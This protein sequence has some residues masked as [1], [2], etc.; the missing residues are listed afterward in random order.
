MSIKFNKK[1]LKSAVLIG[2]PI[3]ACGVGVGVYV[4]VK[5]KTS[6]QTTVIAERNGS[7]SSTTHEEQVHQQNALTNI[8]NVEV[9]PRL[10][11]YDF[12]DQIR[13]VEGKQ[14]I[15]DEFIAAVVNKVIKEMVVTD[16]DIL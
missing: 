3:V 9:F 11:T 8:G 13:I 4:A 12:Y 6:N 2:S 16:G 5:N 10:T 1:I 7:N 15:T 14:I